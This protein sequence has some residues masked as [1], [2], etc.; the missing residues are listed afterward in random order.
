MIPKKFLD[1]TDES[2]KEKTLPV[3]LVDG[4]LTRRNSFRQ[5]LD[6]LGL[7]SLAFDS[8][9]ELMADRFYLFKFGCMIVTPQHGYAHSQIQSA[10]KKH[11]SPMLLVA[12]QDNLA[13]LSLLEKSLFD[14]KKVDVIHESCDSH[15]LNWRLHFLKRSVTSTAVESSFFQFGMYRF[16]LKRRQ[17]WIGEEKI[18]LKPLEFE[19]SLELFQSMNSILT[20]EKLYTQFWDRSAHSK[21]SRRLDVCI[22]NVKKKMRIADD[23][24]LL[25]KSIYGRGYELSSLDF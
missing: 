8:P 3:A 9:S 23:K 6:F 11:N 21:K 14:S 10:M 20:R 24:G 18:R 22:S 15:E 7:A 2:D 13:E 25:L 4:N 17:A 12:A 16:D 5:Q 19:I 1:S